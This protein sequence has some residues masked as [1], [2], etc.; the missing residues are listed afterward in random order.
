MVKSGC[1]GW[2][3]PI[4]ILVRLG[5]PEWCVWGGGGVP[6]GKNHLLK[7]PRN[8]KNMA[9]ENIISGKDRGR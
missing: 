6:F 5:S 7:F 1:R 4:K 2:G 9:G 3:S 8:I